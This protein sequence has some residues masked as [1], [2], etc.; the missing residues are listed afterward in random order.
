[1]ARRNIWTVFQLFR[2][3]QRSANDCTRLRV[4]HPRVQY[5]GKL[6]GKL[7]THGLCILL[8]GKFYKNEKCDI[9][10]IAVKTYNIK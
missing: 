9:E 5:P 1:M 6:A 7:W 2:L 4:Y 3:V 10:Q 8:Y